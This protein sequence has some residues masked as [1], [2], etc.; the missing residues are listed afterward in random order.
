ML[1]ENMTSEE[2]M[3]HL[4]DRSAGFIGVYDDHDG[5]IQVFIKGD[6]VIQNLTAIQE[7]IYANITSG[8]L[9]LE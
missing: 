9:K 2:I 1:I 3:H 7:C 5:D 6:N 8:D 4:A